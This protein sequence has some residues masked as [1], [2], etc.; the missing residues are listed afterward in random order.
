MAVELRQYALEETED[1][2]WRYEIE[3]TTLCV[4]RKA[5]ESEVLD[6]MHYMGCGGTA[7]T[8]HG[9]I[10]I[11]AWATVEVDEIAINMEAG[12]VGARVS[13]ID[14]DQLDEHDDEEGP[15]QFPVN[16]DDEDEFPEP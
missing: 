13:A 5:A 11:N 3:R 8:L 6:R 14:G 4:S 1:G 12:N 2:R 10:P 15:I 9:A 16:P 7:V